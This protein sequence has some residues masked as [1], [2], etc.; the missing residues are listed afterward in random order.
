MITLRTRT[1]CSLLIIATMLPACS[2]Q[3]PPPGPREKRTIY[4]FNP[5]LSHAMEVALENSARWAI[6]QKFTPWK[7]IPDFSANFYPDALSRV[8]QP[9]VTIIH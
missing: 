5:N 9:A 6:Q 8:K 2:K 1:I 7:E 3:G 4:D